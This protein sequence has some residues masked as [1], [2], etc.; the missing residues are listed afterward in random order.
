M[1]FPAVPGADG[2]HKSALPRARGWWGSYPHRAGHRGWKA[3]DRQ[4]PGS[5]GES[6]LEDEGAFGPGVQLGG[7]FAIVAVKD[8]VLRADVRYRDHQQVIACILPGRRAGGGPRPFRY[9]GTVMVDTEPSDDR[10]GVPDWNRAAT[11]TAI[12]VPPPAPLWL[13]P[14]DLPIELLTLALGGR[15]D[16]SVTVATRAADETVVEGFLPDLQPLRNRA[17]LARIDR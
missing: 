5:R 13:F 16:Q 15:A 7:G 1:A 8:H 4:G 3:R 14:F 12:E 9:Y 11:R 17:F 6:V 2:G 10:T